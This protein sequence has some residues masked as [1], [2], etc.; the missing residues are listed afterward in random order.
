M[1]KKKN[2][3][4][5]VRKTAFYLFLGI[6]A[7]ICFIPLYWMVRSSFMKNTDIYVM[8]PFILWPKEMLWS[9]YAD[10]MKAANFGKYAVNTLTIV[11]GCLIGTSLTASMAA[12]AFSRIKWKGR[13]ICF[14]MILTTMMLPGTVTLIPQFLIWRNLHLVDTFWPLILPSFLG[15]GAFNIFLLRQFFLGIP[16]ELDEAARIDGAGALQIYWRIILPLAKSAL[17]VVALFT[18][19]NNWND[20]FAPIIYLNSKENFTLALGLLQFRGDYSTKW[21]LL[22]AGSTIVATPC[23]L[24]YL[25]GQ[26]Y[27]IEGISLT[28]L[29]A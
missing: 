4:F 13:S 15:G 27:L 14:A 1:K 17:V 10:A 22:M 19:L 29:K 18:F 8:D 28:G 25:I 9:N 2:A 23:I 7:F 6:L 11:A 5:Y 16:K 3:A 12:Y 21:N 20:F 26:R 24:I